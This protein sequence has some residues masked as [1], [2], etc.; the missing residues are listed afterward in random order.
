LRTG[1]SL[2]P[3]GGFRLPGGAAVGKKLWERHELPALSGKFILRKT[4]LLWI[5]SKS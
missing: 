4:L 5:Q 3:D 1:L 2:P